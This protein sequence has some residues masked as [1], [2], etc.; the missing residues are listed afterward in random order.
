MKKLFRLGYVNDLPIC[1]ASASCNAKQDKD[2]EEETFGSQPLVQIIADG[3]KEKDGARH[4]QA[5]LADQ[6]K[7]L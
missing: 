3:E 2:G 4:G 7:I 6:G 5:E 1:R